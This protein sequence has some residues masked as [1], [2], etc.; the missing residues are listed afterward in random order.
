[1]PFSSCRRREIAPRQATLL[2]PLALFSFPVFFPKKGESTRDCFL[3]VFWGLFVPFF[4]VRA[5]NSELE[6]SEFNDDYESLEIPRG[7]REAGVH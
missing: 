4:I 1:M 5:V 3:S 6:V 7:L 2:S